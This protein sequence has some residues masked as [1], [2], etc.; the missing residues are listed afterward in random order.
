MK[1]IQLQQFGDA[2][3]L[4]MQEVE[5]PLLKDDQVLIKIKASSVNPI[6]IKIRK[7]FMKDALPKPF[8][9]VLGW[10]A[11]GIIGAIG[12]NVTR[13]HIGD[14][15]YTMPNFMQGGTYAQYVAVNENEVALKPSTI[16]FEDAAALPM[17]AGAA[18]TALFKIA[19]LKAG[20]KILIHGAAGSVGSLAVQMA[21]NIGAYVIGT[22]SD[23]GIN[24]LKKLKTDGIIDYTNTDFEKLVKDVDVVLDLVGGATQ[25]KS[26]TVLKKGGLLLSTVS[27][28]SKDKATEYGVTAV[29]I[30]TKPDY[31]MLDEIALMAD[32]GKLQPPII[33]LM[34]LDD[35]ANAHTLLETGKIKGKIIFKMDTT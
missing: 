24:L 15:V 7:G 22:A 29:F 2:S 28:P 34:R 6:D 31:K 12:K 8:P 20:Q 33:N 25:E 11:A 35:A 19:N 17:V 3:V 10:E 16:S 5:V 23:E 9:I 1:T 21:K 13:L 32:T 18:Y 26:F 27:P 30:F 14:E 4:Q